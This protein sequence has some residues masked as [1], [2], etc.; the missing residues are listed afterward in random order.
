VINKYFC[1]EP[2][3]YEKMFFNF[4]NVRLVDTNQAVFD[5]W[6]ERLDIRDFVVKKGGLRLPLADIEKSISCGKPISIIYS[7]HEIRNLK[8]DEHPTY[9][10][11]LGVNKLQIE[12]KRLLNPYQQLIEDIIIKKNYGGL[13]MLDKLVFTA[14]LVEVKVDNDIIFDISNAVTDPTMVPQIER[15]S[16]QG[17]NKPV[18]SFLAKRVQRS[19]H[20]NSSHV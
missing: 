6:K 11:S 20:E 18:Y 17:H 5:G 3:F 14:N 7:L 9:H 13:P 8:T 10:S 1:M 4:Q 19:L 15:A 16:G 2:T 12:N